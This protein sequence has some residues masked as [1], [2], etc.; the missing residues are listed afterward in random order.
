MI[1]GMRVL[2]FVPSL[3]APAGLSYLAD[4]GADVVRIAPLS[5]GAHRWPARR[6]ARSPGER[7]LSADRNLRT[8]IVDLDDPEALP[9][10]SKLLDDR[11]VLIDGLAPGVLERL[12]LGRGVLRA[13]WPALIHASISG[14]GVAGPLRDVPADDLLVQARTG[15][16]KATGAH[17]PT[18]AGSPIVEQH[19]AA[20]LATGVLAAYAKL[21][22]TGAGTELEMSL[23]TAAI[24][25]QAEPLTLWFADEAEGSRFR[26]HASLGSWFH[27]A[28]YGVYALVDGYVAISTG[29]NTGKLAQA[30]DCEALLPYVASDR[31]LN[32]DAYAQILADELSRWRWEDLDRRL[33]LHGLWYQRVT[34]F[35]ELAT[36]PQIVATEALGSADL[37]AVPVRFL[38]HPIR[39][40]GALRPVV[41]KG[42]PASG[43][44][45][46]AAIR[47]GTA[48][49][50]SHAHR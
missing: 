22:E 18:P 33:A 31:L 6:A 19:A 28:P 38:N 5:H 30:L 29:P 36:D 1:A 45:S 15:L 25:L 50:S 23:L 47:T 41:L 2:A 20:L 3:T 27:E 4:L 43:P 39:Y 8:I 14:W 10:L 24:Y 7:L 42:A 16:A 49:E 26:R 34:D 46:A 9:F 21:L 32:R 37:D 12:G 11:N 35:A 44:G 40:D 13:R 48:S 17:R